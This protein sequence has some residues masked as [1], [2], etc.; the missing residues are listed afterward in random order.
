MGFKDEIKNK[1]EN[2]LNG[3]RVFTEVKIK[4]IKF[5]YLFGYMPIKRE[6]LTW[7]EEQIK[8]K[9][10]I[11]KRRYQPK[12]YGYPILC[13]NNVCIDGH[14]RIVV[15]KELYGENY[16]LKVCKNDTN[17]YSQL[18]LSMIYSVL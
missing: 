15:L 2:Y 14:H 6:Y 3:D 16:K 8:L 5:K 7:T 1:I 4:D 10:T 11:K 9:D 12:K 18:I 17:W 13:G